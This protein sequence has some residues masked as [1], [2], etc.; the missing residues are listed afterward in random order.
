MLTSIGQERFAA[1][2]TA[3]TVT[4]DASSGSEAE[5]DTQAVC[6]R[7]RNARGDEGTFDG[8]GKA[9]PENSIVVT[10]AVA[11]LVAK[12]VIKHLAGVLS[13][14]L[15]QPEW[16]TSVKVIICPECP[17]PQQYVYLCAARGCKALFALFA[18]ADD[19]RASTTSTASNNRAPS[20]K[21]RSSSKDKMHSG[22]EPEKK[23]MLI[24]SLSDA[25]ISQVLDVITKLLAQCTKECVGLLKSALLIRRI[26]NF[27]ARTHR[28]SQAATRVFNTFDGS[29]EEE[30]YL[31]EFPNRRG[32][33]TTE[34]LLDPVDLHLERLHSGKYAP[35]APPSAL[36]GLLSDVPTVLVANLET[37][38]VQQIMASH[39]HPTKAQVAIIKRTQK[40]YTALDSL[41]SQL[42]AIVKETDKQYP[43]VIAVYLQVYVSVRGRRIL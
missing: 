29:E 8:T 3:S 20:S 31:D 39:T 35:P 38:L 5:S 23:H 6:R 1:E 37:W 40:A 22:P 36:F 14:V 24:D 32:A 9:T 10:K 34:Q 42:F 4:S 25:R 41:C 27:V 15:K 28:L 17:D 21:K 16:L 11:D 12:E 33:D 18:E 26:L 7:H 30:D 13:M 43:Q 2:K 19:D